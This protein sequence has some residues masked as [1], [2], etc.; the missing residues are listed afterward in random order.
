MKRLCLLA[1]LL[2]F[3]VI[4]AQT[5]KIIGV[6]KDDVTRNPLAGANVYLKDTRMGTTTD[7]DGTF[8][9]ENIA[10]GSYE[11]IVDFLGYKTFQKTVTVK[12]DETV[13][14][15]ILLVPAII[16]G[17]EVVVLG[18]RAEERKTPVVFTTLD[19]EYIREVHTV[20]DIPMMLTEIPNVFAY[21]DAGN[22]TG[23]SYLKVRGFDQKR[24]GVMINGIPLND[25][26]DHQ[27][28]WVDMPDFAESL[29]DIQ[30]QRGVGTSLY[31]VSTFGGSLNLLTS[32]YTD[33]SSPE[34]YANFGS[35]QTRRYGVKLS[36]PLFN[37]KYNFHVRF[38][39]LVSDG[40]RERSGTDQWA[41]FTSLS[42]FG[43]R[44]YT[45]INIYGGKEITDAA[46]YASPESELKR[47]PRH[48]PITYSN[49]ID[50]FSQPHFEF[51]H[52]YKLSDNSYWKNTLFYIRG[53]GYYE[54][55]KSERNLWRYGLW[56]D[57]DTAPESDLI[58]QKWVKKNQ[59]GWISQL[60]FTH[61]NGGELT[62]GSYLSLFD[63]DHW[64]E[65]EW[66]QEQQLVNFTPNFKYYQYFGNKSY[67]TF[68]INELYPILPNLTAM[69]NLHFQYIR[70]RFRHGEVANFRGENRHEFEVNYT[71]FNPRF[72]LNYNLNDRINLF[73]NFSIAQ[74]E[75]ADD[76]LY[77]IWQ[78]PDDLGVAPLFRR[79]TPIKRNGQIVKIKWED[80]VVKPE[81]LYDLELGTGY[82]TQS[83]QAKMNLFFMFFRNEIVPFSQVDKD[84]FPIRGNADATLH[85]G[86]E[87]SFKSLL[88][89]RMEFS[90]NFAFNDNRYLKFKQYTY[91]WVKDTMVM[92]DLS[93]NQIAGFPNILANARLTYRGRSLVA[94]L[95]W[96]HV[97]KQ[98]LDN[99]NRE[100]RIIP[101][102][103]LLNAH[104]IYR[105]GN[106]F[107]LSNIEITLRLN[108]ILNKRYY[109]AGY[110]DSWAGE[111][112]YWPGAEFNFIAGIRVQL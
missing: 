9:L 11:L 40:Y 34:I 62:I 42:R 89:F 47:N 28:Y 69:A 36:V 76:E 15:E 98:Y 24:I 23:Y 39:R 27:V 26:E 58:R 63:S 2:T 68:Y 5:G 41:F 60:G 94:S 53:V 82:I 78:G 90:G 93:G 64:G 31:G 112:F 49:A 86:I 20:E 57:P 21:S 8:L 106:R 103:S 48:N 81:K 46:W 70:Y 92:E 96:Q 45:Q 88:P 56:P 37:N 101:A 35:Y 107:G 51:H 22:G 110:Y 105:M 95:H 50:N 59:Y 77:D 14:L 19:R 73:G 61:G 111:N 54:S 13:Q 66:I 25:P 6:V 16:P 17:E 85:Q 109:T 79:S 30:F 84:G 99:T 65:I 32:S 97:G 7:E 91:D 75:P 12:K 102:F 18:T 83:L 29:Q 72:G 55:Y 80:P 10:E 33:L 1:L 52:T 74:R 71:F 108:N 44:S 38:S 3:S 100:D 67:V 87:L 4:G 43:E 104:F